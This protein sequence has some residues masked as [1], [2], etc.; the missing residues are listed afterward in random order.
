MFGFSNIIL[1]LCDTVSGW[2]SA[3]IAWCFHIVSPYRQ[4]RILQRSHQKR[5]SR[6]TCHLMFRMIPFAQNCDTRQLNDSLHT[7]TDTLASVSLTPPPPPPPH[8][9]PSPLCN[10]H[11]ASFVLQLKVYSIPN[12]MICILPTGIAPGYP[13]F[14]SHASH[15]FFR[16]TDRI[17]TALAEWLLL[18]CVTCVYVYFQEKNMACVCVLQEGWSWSSRIVP[19]PHLCITSCIILPA[20]THKHTHTHQLTV[21]RKMLAH[22]IFGTIHDVVLLALQ[23]LT[24]LLT[25]QLWGS[26]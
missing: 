19:N 10:M 23:M 24:V 5:S 18:V 1:D 15:A 25:L 4:S 6:H 14:F 20:H 7:Q 21:L 3:D 9:P 16:R 22:I 26:L 11:N 17:L 8:R 2:V 12:T 13:E